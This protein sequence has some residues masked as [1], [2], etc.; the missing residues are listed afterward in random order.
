MAVTEVIVSSNSCVF[1]PL[2]G[3]ADLLNLV[4]DL[5]Q[6]LSTI[7][8][9]AFYLALHLPEHMTESLHYV[10]QLQEL[11]NVANARLTAAVAANAHLSPRL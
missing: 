7:E 9:I 4:H 1:P 3:A 10:A 11:V 5:R 6:P 8:M 2:E